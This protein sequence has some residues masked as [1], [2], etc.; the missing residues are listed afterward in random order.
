MSIFHE[1]FD[2]KGRKT[3][4]SFSSPVDLSRFDKHNWATT[5]ED[6]WY[7]AE[8]LANVK[9]NK[10]LTRNQIA[11]LRKADEFEIKLGRLKR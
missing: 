6:L 5:E 9:H 1:W 11:N 2:K 10:I 8:Y 4:R 7:I 3:L